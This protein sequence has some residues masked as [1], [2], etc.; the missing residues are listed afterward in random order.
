ML[1][2]IDE[3]GDTGLKVVAGSS[4]YFVISLVIFEDHEEA[5]A[6]DRQIEELKSDL[7][8]Y[9]DSE[10]KFNKLSK[11]KRISFIKA[12][13]PFSFYYFGIVI[14]KDPSKLYGDG[15]KY[16]GSFYK[17][18]CNLVFQNAKP[19]LRDATVVI[20]GSGT[21]EF[22]RQLQAYLRKKIGTGI[23]KKIKIQD[24][25]NNNLIQLADMIA[26]SLHRS[27]TEKNDKDEY[28]KILGLKEM[29]VQIWPK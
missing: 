1:V 3:S 6:C 10:F 23:I 16:K 2:F 11:E 21:R 8:I 28:R 14:D 9:Q 15:F 20:D 18:A 26:G 13:L 25:R 29:R 5:I 22:K 17:Y 4:R 24:S 12:V 19:Y 27:L 7:H